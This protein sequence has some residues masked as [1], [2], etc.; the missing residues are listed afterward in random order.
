MQFDGLL[1]IDKP[2]DLTS[3][4]VVA[5]LRKALRQKSVGHTGTLDP[6]ATG[7]MIMV[8][9]EATKLSDYL[10]A[11]DKSYRMK[12]KFGLTTDTL[13]RTGKVLSETPCDL[14]PSEI[15]RAVAQLQGDFE[16]KVP[17]FS[18]A[19]VDGKK[20]YEYARSGEPVPQPVKTMSF[21]D[22]H[23]LATSSSQLE[24]VLSCSKGSF[25]R[26]WASEIGSLMGTGAVM[27]ELR[28]LRVGPWS[29]ENALTLEQIGS[30][31]SLG[32][33][34]VPMSQAL[35]ELKS[36][37]AAP[38]EMRLMVNGQIPRDMVSRLIPEQKQ[39]IATGQSV[40]IKVLAPGGELLAILGAEPGQGLKIRR[41]FRSIA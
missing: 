5:F 24:I 37:V 18:A 32:A 12:V 20:L 11:A 26:S 41:V 36:V 23:V 27:E 35:P 2:Q 22:A 10:I 40:F 28:R 21:S 17:A 30:G 13:D 8:L 3:H 14:N 39:A 4:D 7:L 9:G 15:L 1:L 25:M 29:I 38:K 16:W 31:Q 19:K 33:A 6:L 34:F